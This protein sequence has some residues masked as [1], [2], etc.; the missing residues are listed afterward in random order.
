[1]K[2]ENTEEL[3][4]YLEANADKL[5][6]SNE[7]N[8]KYIQAARDDIK[9]RQR[10]AARLQAM[11]KNKLHIT[12]K[13]LAKAVGANVRTLQGWETGR[14][15][16]PVAVEILMKLM[17]EVPVVRKKLLSKN[18]VLTSRSNR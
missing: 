1:M 2:A 15:D 13:I 10:R 9:A 4:K 17:E 5:V 8:E 6:D 14:Q 11:R 7:D 3:E 16:Y 18:S 12:Q